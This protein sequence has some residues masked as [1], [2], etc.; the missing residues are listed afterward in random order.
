MS[1][2]LPEVVYHLEPPRA[3]LV[4]ETFL[5]I[6]PV[7]GH[8]GPLRY[9]LLEIGARLA[10]T[11]HRA[12]VLEFPGQNGRSGSFSVARSCAG[13]THF[14]ATWVRDR[15][16]AVRLFGICS[17]G[18]AALAAAAEV[19][20]VRAVFCWE[21][22]ARYSYSPA[23]VQVFERR[24]GVRF[25]SATALAPVQAAE[26]TSRVRCPI[27]FGLSAPSRDTSQQEQQ[28]L[29]DLAQQADVLAVDH[30]GHFPGEQPGAAQRL[31]ACL[32]RWVSDPGERLPSSCGQSG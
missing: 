10:A 1:D 26:V 3:A 19:P 8:H 24:F 29:A 2:C 15:G 13:L 5:L 12:M 6:P 31:A 7:C 27:R 25:C 14:V 11:G 30:V 4:K 18:L 32:R 16:V 17:G 21:V 20:D 28:G 22:G 23:A 9:G